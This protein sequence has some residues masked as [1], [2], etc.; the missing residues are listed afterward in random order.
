[1]ENYYSVLGVPR[2][3]DI[4]QVKRSY[5]KKVLTCHPDHNKSP[6]AHEEFIQINRAYEVLKNQNSRLKYDYLLSSYELGLSMKRTKAWSDSR[7]YN[8]QSRG[9]AVTEEY[10]PSW[11][12]KYPVKEIIIGIVFITVTPNLLLFIFT[13]IFGVQ[14]EDIAQTIRSYEWLSFL[15]N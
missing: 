8:Y 10:M 9:A 1:M 15:L 12:K 2:E 14:N 5:R 13:L 4:N 11:K 3:C 7:S 6:R